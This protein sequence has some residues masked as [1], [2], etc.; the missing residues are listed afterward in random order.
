[1]PSRRQTVEVESIS[2]ENSEVIDSNVEE[3]AIVDQGLA[4]GARLSAALV[5]FGRPVTVDSLAKSLDESEEEIEAALLNLA[6]LYKDEIH[7]FTVQQV[8]GAFQIRTSPRARKTIE[9]LIP[10]KVK[11]FSKA[12][13]ETLAIIAY[14]QPIQRAEIEAIRGVDALP[15]LKTLIDSK[16]IRQVGRDEEIGKPVLY[17]TTETFLERFGLNDLSELPTLSELKEFESD[18]GESEGEVSEPEIAELPELEVP[19]LEVPELE[20][21]ALELSSGSQE[22]AEGGGTDF[23]GLSGPTSDLESQPSA[24]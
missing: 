2:I 13:A 22:G 11:K 16:V 18:P 1:M 6:A 5:A 3:D 8:Q 12:A 17:A 7:G 14:K 4:L 15:T 24:Q 9:K 21:T 23:E 19:E 10:P 20:V